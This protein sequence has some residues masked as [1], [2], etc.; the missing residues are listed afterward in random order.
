MRRLGF[1]PHPGQLDELA[2]LGIAGAL[3]H[4][5]NAAP[6]EPE[7]PSLG[8]DDD[9]TALTRWW[10]E[11]MARPDAGLHEKLV[12]FW[13]G[14]L[15]S[16]LNKGEPLMLLRQHELLRRNALGNFRTLLQEIT[17]DA[18]MLVWLDGAGSTSDAPNENYAR[19]A[20]ELF[21]LGHGNYTE[22][23]I[24]QASFA[25]SGW[26]IDWEH[27]LAVVFDPE[28]GPHE[29]YQ[30]LGRE[31]AS[32][33]EVI[34][35]LCDQP[36]CATW[37]TSKLY[38]FLVGE[39]P[40]DS[41]RD[42]LAGPFRDGGLEIRPLV[43]SIVRHPD[44]LERRL[45]RHRPPLE[46][47]L[48]ARAFLDVEIDMWALHGLGQMPLQPPNVAGWP[49]GPRW[50]SAG[51]MYAKAQ[52]AYDHCWDTEVV[53]TDD[54]VGTLLRRAGLA[55]VSDETRAALD[56]AAGRIDGRRERASVLSALILCSPE[57]S[58]S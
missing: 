5:L 50:Q 21:A 4:L 13:H 1:G 8:T 39:W 36:A 37:I 47:Y 24:R 32:A 29:T 19:E 28:I 14:L 53:D 2:P 40:E 34:D 41:V 17:V 22:Q 46:W 43:E 23:D 6:L 18:A 3:D 42:E 16:S 45:N 52:I 26:T 20:M 48:H 38:E 35:V 9:Y 58:I 15:T 7:R 55:E 49:A 27:D 51:A 30:V 31:V 44:F 25:L 12:W 10:I 57:F 56:D 54:P 11:V 33:A